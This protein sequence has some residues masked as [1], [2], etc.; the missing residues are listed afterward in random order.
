M[1][2][3]TYRW[4]SYLVWGILLSLFLSLALIYSQLPA[5]GAT[6]DLESF[7]AQGFHIQWLLEERPGGLQVDDIVVR[8]GSHTVDEWLNG[9]APGPE[10]EDD[11]IVRYEIL[12]RGLPLTLYIRMAPVSFH[13]ILD[14]WLLQALI[15]LGLILV[16][17]YVFW[18]RSDEVAARLLMLFCISVA[19][20]CWGD[21]YNFQYAIF[22]RLPV[23][24]LQFILE[25]ASFMLM[26]A[27]ILNFALVF[28]SPHPVIT[29]HPALAYLSIYLF[30]P[31]VLA[32]VMLFSSTWS[33]AILNGSHASW[34]VV[35]VQA[36]LAIGIG[37]RSLRIEREAVKRAQLRW[38]LWGTLAGLVVVI[39]G[40]IFPLVLSNRPFVPHPIVMLLTVLLIII[41]AI[42]ILRYRLFDI[43][44]VINRTLVYGTL[45]IL[46]ASIY[47][48]LVRL[49]TLVVQVVSKHP[50]QTLVVF[51][52]TLSI[53]WTVNPLYQ[54]I[55]K[56]ID[57]AFYREKL[58]YRKLL[59]E[60]TER[61]S[62]CILPDQLAV[63][64]TEEFPRRLQIKKASL[65]I[66]DPVGERLKPE[67]DTN[68][69]TLSLDHPLIREI[70][71]L[72]KPLVRLQPSDKLSQESRAWLDEH[73]VE[74]V[75][76][77]IAGEELVGLY[78]LGSKESGEAYYS[79]EVRM[80]NSLGQQAAIGVQNSRLLSAEQEQRKLAEA[81]KQAAEVVSSTLDLEQVLDLILEQVSRVVAGDAFNVMLLEGEFARVV[82]WRGYEQFDA[83]GRIAN[84]SLRV[85]EYPTMVKM[86]D[87]GQPLCIAD[88]LHHPDW[89]VLDKWDWLKSYVSTPIPSG[90]QMVGFLDVDGSRSDQFGPADAQRLK[91]FA[92]H[93]GIALQNARM[94]KDRLDLLSK[95]EEQA[96]QV[97]QIIDTVP[98]GVLLLD[99]EKRFIL[100]NPAAQR[101]LYQ[102]TG[103]H[104]PDQPLS[105]LAGYSVDD[106]LSSYTSV[107][108][109]EITI[110]GPPKRIFEIAAHPL[111]IG[112]QSPG[113]V[114][115]LRD[116]TSERE[117]QAQVYL[118]ERLVT[119]G[120]LAAGISHDFNNILAAILVYVDL[121][122]LDPNLS[123]SSQKQLDIIQNQIRRATGLVRQ[124][125]D[126]SRSSAM[127]QSN[128]DLYSFIK[129]LEGLLEHILPENIQLELD[130]S[131]G[132]YTIRADPMRLQQAFMNLYLNAR[133]AMPGGGKFI[134]RL[135]RFTLEP[136]ERPPYPDLLPGEWIGIRVQDTGVGIP[137]NVLPH[138][139]DPFFT[140]K[141]VG[142]GTGLGLAQAYGIIKQHGG[143]I[144]V[145]SQEGEGTTFSIYFPALETENG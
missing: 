78:N 98:E 106:I 48:V 64:L 6:G 10:W 29:R 77:L 30:H 14:R 117:I 128:L 134:F 100:T 95:T 137:A 118:Q 115:V 62:T 52:S 36:L 50:D 60:M 96:R 58:N 41:F 69:P 111:E 131:P 7:T 84:I 138:I 91:A 12:R 21:A 33:Q 70:R 1:P 88:T 22:S 54:R 122:C 120:Q 75:I 4:H 34:I 24:W 101:F 145:Q 139:F 51:L 81:L 76:P 110:E 39:P 129:E 80:L 59:P 20:Q 113:W 42:P 107:P 9:A 40:Y 3:K 140:T 25:Y 121:V 116:V 37:I 114:V 72:R 55:Q 28:P 85:R 45:T 108:W 57:R 90:G 53:A 141:P 5:D 38:I 102:L 46:L 82:R 32:L 23:F 15:M 143:S 68:L 17:A 130:C 97:Q 87:D 109:H 8:A 44:V 126:F 67:G 79:E 16:G 73:H 92:V 136:G 27:S 31:L 86:L 19:V 66:L 61:M 123:P 43:E 132:Q 94:Y 47:L 13:S 49:L 71:R 127:E 74:L 83:T 119:V 144:D 11:G 124:I 35:V 99:E 105:S 89:I 2:T 133:D 104:H 103:A 65:S 18:K 142:K 135:D 63:L 56:V 93:A 26:Y 125:L 112:T